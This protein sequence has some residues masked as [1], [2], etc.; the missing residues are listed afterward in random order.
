MIERTFKS[1]IWNQ[2]LSHKH[3]LNKYWN[4]ILIHSRNLL[5][6]MQFCIQRTHSVFK[7]CWRGYMASFLVLRQ[8][9]KLISA[10]VNC[11][12]DRK[13][14][15]FGEKIS[16]FKGKYFCDGVDTLQTSSYFWRGL[17][18]CSWCNMLVHRCLIYICIVYV[19]HTGCFLQEVTVLF[20]K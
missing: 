1:I 10:E 16:C 5:K 17:H 6:E 12:G 14:F 9:V 11:E 18:S 13:I 19:Q 20:K 8:E 3:P 2:F 4:L 15:N 7:V